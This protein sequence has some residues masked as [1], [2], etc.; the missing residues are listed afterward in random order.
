MGKHVWWLVRGT[1][2]MV[3]E[4][5]CSSCSDEQLPCFPTDDKPHYYYRERGSALV[6]GQHSWLEA[7]V[8]GSSSARR[9]LA[10]TSLLLSSNTFKIGYGR[11]LLRPSQFIYNPAFLLGYKLIQL[12]KRC[13]VN[14]KWYHETSVASFSLVCASCCVFVLLI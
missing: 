2:C 5:Q 1:P 10:W 6:S 8:W 4:F 7:G 11:F 9:P 12:M 14:I 3:K 13:Q